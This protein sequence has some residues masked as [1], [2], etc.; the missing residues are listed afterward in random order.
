MTV[1]AASSPGFGGTKRV[2]AH[3]ANGRMPYRKSPLRRART[4]CLS[5]TSFAQWRRTRRLT[6]CRLNGRS[7]LPKLGYFF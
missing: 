6:Q 4:Y 7:V 1:S 2:P 5:L 3:G